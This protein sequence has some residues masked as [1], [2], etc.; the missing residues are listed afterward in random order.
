MK[1][2]III[3]ITLI[4]CIIPLS[5][6]FP[7]NNGNATK[8]TTTVYPIEFIVSNLYTK[9]EII[10]IYPNGS[11][12]STYKL[13]NKQTEEYAKSTNLFIYNGLTEEKEIARKL[14]NK[15]KKIQII[16]VNYGLKYSNS[17]EELWLSPSN[18]LMMAN[19]IKNDLI[20]ITNNKYTTNEI[21]ENYKKLEEELSI[22]DAN[23]KAIADNTDETKKTLVIAD[24]A[25]QF[26]ED[27]GFNIINISDKNNITNSIKEKFKNGTYTTIYVRANTTVMD[28]IKDFVDNYKAKL[29][30]IDTMNTLTEDERNNNED[31]LTIMNKFLTDLSNNVLN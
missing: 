9:Q 12:T 2:K 8:I 25:F 23:L 20:E 26:L 28:E 11:N 16:D 13:T 1:R 10:S 14:V 6:C 17:I 21:N 7:E 3:I 27:Y 24:N 29:T 19:T 4:L 30:E 31:Y 5:G 15:N 22:L 18:Y